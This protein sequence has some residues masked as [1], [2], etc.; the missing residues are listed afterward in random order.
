ML[1]GIMRERE[2]RMFGG[3]LKPRSAFGFAQGQEQIYASSFCYLGEG[4]EHK[5]ETSQSVR[6]SLWPLAILGVCYVVSKFKTLPHQ[7]ID[8]I[9]PHVNSITQGSRPDKFAARS[10]QTQPSPTDAEQCSKCRHPETPFRKKIL[11]VG[12]LI[13]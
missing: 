4:L 7:P 3:L 6:G 10:P 8:R 5:K 11:E 1:P 13:V 12:P 9:S 2:A